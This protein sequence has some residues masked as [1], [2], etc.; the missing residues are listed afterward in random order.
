MDDV[1]F[2]VSIAKYS[3]YDVV[4]EILFESRLHGGNHI[5]SENNI[6]AARLILLNKYPEF[7][8]SHPKVKK[9]WINASIKKYVYFDLVKNKEK[10]LEVLPTGFQYSL[11]KQVINHP[12]GSMLLRRI[13]CNALLS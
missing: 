2:L 7:Y 6:L 10:L 1:D 13:I 12:P 9:Q 8:N 11:I 4:D 3:N 5:N